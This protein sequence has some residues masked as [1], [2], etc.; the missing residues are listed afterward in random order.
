M[1]NLAIKLTKMKSPNSALAF[2]LETAEDKPRK[3]R[4]IER[5]RYIESLSLQQATDEQVDERDYRPNYIYKYFQS[6][7]SW[8]VVGWLIVLFV[9]KG[10]FIVTGRNTWGKRRET[11][12]HV[13]LSLTRGNHSRNI[14]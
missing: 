14:V 4:T 2:S 5:A 9:A 12:V 3:W 10:I 1:Y 13:N 8:G 7:S 11:P 6:S